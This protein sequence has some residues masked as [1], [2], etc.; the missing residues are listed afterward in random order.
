MR[1]LTTEL[2]KRWIDGGL[3]EHNGKVKSDKIKEDLIEWA[4]SLVAVGTWDRLTD[5]LTTT[6]FLLDFDWKK[7]QVLSKP[8][9]IFDM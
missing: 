5:W 9:R 8:S 1:R 6:S 3:Q 4:S 7:Y 2:Q